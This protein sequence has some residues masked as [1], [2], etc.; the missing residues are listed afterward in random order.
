MR[1]MSPR[2][3]ETARRMHTS[4]VAAV[5]AFLRREHLVLA[6]FVILAAAL[7]GLATTLRTAGAYLTGA[8]C[9]AVAGLLGAGAAAPA[10]SRAAMADR[11]GGALVEALRGGG[12]TGL[13]LASLALLAIGG[14]YAALGAG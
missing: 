6:A 4:S 7:L 5:L 8:V 14:W 13:A 12:V 10:S 2:P 11:P 1:R 9:A 3:A